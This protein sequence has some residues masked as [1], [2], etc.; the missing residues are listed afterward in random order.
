MRIQYVRLPPNGALDFR[1]GTAVQPSL[2]DL[3]RM[4]MGANIY[5][6]G[7]SGDRGDTVSIGLRGGGSLESITFTAYGAIPRVLLQPR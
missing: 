4:L 7:F 5:T 6:V 1:L 3:A 2:H